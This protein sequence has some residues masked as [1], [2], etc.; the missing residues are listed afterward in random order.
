MKVKSCRTCR[1]FRYDE[2]D[3]VRQPMGQFDDIE[4]YD[5]FCLAHPCF[6]GTVSVKASTRACYAHRYAKKY[7]SK[8]IER[9][10]TDNQ[11]SDD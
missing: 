2:H 8:E 10:K 6:N 4:T 11:K 1:Y 7:L 3:L 5:G 9:L